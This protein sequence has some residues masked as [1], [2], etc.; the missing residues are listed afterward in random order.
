M[1]EKHL[2]AISNGHQKMLVFLLT[3]QKSNFMKKYFF[4]LSLLSLLL[5]AACAQAPD[6]DKAATTE[7]QDVSATAGGD[8][9]Q[10]DPAASKMEWIGTKVSGYHSGVVPIKSGEL[11]VENGNVTGGKFVMDMANLDVTGPAG[12]PADMNGKLKGHLQSPDFFD[13]ANHPEATFEVTSVAPFSGTAAAE[14]EDPRQADISEYKVANPTH[15]VSGNLTLKGMTKNVS[16]PAQITVTGNSLDAIAKFNVDRSQWN[17]TYPGK[18]DD[19]IRNDIH[20]GLSVRAS[21]ASSTP[22]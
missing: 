21:N 5:L 22:Q 15:T 18:P 1:L 7:A 19:L 10:V 8:A 13:V 3:N 4:G 9:W 14:Q 17:I 2:F 11:K 12:V 16:F 20:I 6:S